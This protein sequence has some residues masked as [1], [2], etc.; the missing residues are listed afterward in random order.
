MIIFIFLNFKSCKYFTIPQSMVSLLLQSLNLWFPFCCWPI[1]L[2]ALPYLIAFLWYL[3]FGLQ[4][5][6]SYSL[7][8]R[9][10]YPY[11]IS[12]LSLHS[13]MLFMSSLILV[14]LQF[15]LFFSYIFPFCGYLCY[16]A[17]IDCCCCI[18]FCFLVSFLFS[19]V[20]IFHFLQ[21]YFFLLLF[22][23][24]LEV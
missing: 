19:F 5:L 16:P 8:E 7:L 13:Y 24:F 14:I 15:D 10:T 1:H 22:L 21:I 23:F 2:C 3:F 20:N 12:F 6:A 17:S 18:P 9:I 11:Y 4:I